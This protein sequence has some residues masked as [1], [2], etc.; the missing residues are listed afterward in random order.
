MAEKVVEDN[1][2][3]EKL[4][5]ELVKDPICVQAHQLANRNRQRK[6]VE[7]VPVSADTLWD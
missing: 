7:I 3:Q 4:A 2:N 1:L 6:V 5:S